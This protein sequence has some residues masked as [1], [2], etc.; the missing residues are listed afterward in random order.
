MGYDEQSDEAGVGGCGTKIDGAV[1]DWAGCR[2]GVL[3]KDS[4][5]G[6]V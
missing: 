1:R 5:D 2:C 3:V 4:M 6:K